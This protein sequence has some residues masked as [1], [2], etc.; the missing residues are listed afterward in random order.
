MQQQFAIYRV[1]LNLKIFSLCKGTL[2]IFWDTT[3]R[4]FPF[5]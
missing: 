2:E 3:A 5:T 1:E 4:A